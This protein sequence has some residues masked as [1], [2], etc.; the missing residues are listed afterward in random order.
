[1]NQLLARQ[2]EEAVGSTLDGVSPG[3]D[4]KAQLRIAAATVSDAPPGL[5]TATTV[6]GV[7]GQDDAAAVESLVGDI[8][9]EF[10]LEGE[11]R[12]HVGSFSV[13]FSGTTSG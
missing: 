9:E 13:R 4:W 5:I 8:A 7:L 3:L 12:M 2:I 6:I 10:G 1:M 11:L